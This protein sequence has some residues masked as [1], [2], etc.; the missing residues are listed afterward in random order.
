[1]KNVTKAT[2]FSKKLSAIFLDKT[3]QVRRLIPDFLK[4]YSN[5]KR[6]MSEMKWFEVAIAILTIGAYVNQKL[7]HMTRTKFG[8]YFKEYLCIVFYQ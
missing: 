6:Q 7:N 5:W 3:S 1:M 4:G 8:Q 2:S